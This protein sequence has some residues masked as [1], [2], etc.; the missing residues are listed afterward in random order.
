MTVQPAIGSIMLIDDNT[1]DQRLCQRLIERSGLVGRFVGF[2]SAEDALDHLKQPDCP[3]I[4]AILLDVNMP[5][6]D[7]FEF[8]EAATADLGE[9]FANMIVM[10]LTTSLDPRDQKRAQ[11]FAVVKDYCN[12]PLLSEYLER[13]PDLLAKHRT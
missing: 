1:I 3:A 8:L 5:R 9:R 10:M 11:E 12:K 6:M 2:L 4:D 7:G 13:L